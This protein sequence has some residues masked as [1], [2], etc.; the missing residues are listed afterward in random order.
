MARLLRWG[1]SRRDCI[2]GLLAPVDTEP[3]RLSSSGSTRRP[4]VPAHQAADLEISSTSHHQ[5]SDHSAGQASSPLLLYKQ[6]ELPQLEC[7]N[8]VRPCSRSIGATRPRKNF[9]PKCVQRVLDE[10]Y[11]SRA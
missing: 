7:G 5:D 10:I 1:S 9:R 3:P 6:E 2:G 11:L 8:W 4:E